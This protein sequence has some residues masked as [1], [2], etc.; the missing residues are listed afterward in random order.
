MTCFGP[1]SV[2]RLQHLH[3]LV[4]HRVGREVD[5]RLHRRDRDELEEVVLEDVADRAGLLVVAGAPLDADRLGDR[6]LDV[7]DELPVP[8]RLEDAVREPQ[9]QHVLNRLLAEVVVDPEHLFLGEMLLKLGVQL[10]RRLEVVT[11]GLLDDQPDPPLGGATRG[12]LVHDRADCARRDCEVVDAVAT[13]PALVVELRED[14]AQF[15]LALVVCEV[16]R[17]VVH[18]GGEVVPHLLVE[19]V[20]RMLLHR[21]LHPLAEP[22][23]ALLGARRTDDPEVLGKQLTDRERVHRG[24]QL[25]RRQ[26]ARRP[27]DDEDAAVR[28]TAKTEPVGERVVVLLRHHSA[29]AAS[30]AWPPNW[31]RSAAFTLAAN[32]SSWRDANRANNAAVITGTG[33]SSAIASAIVQR[34]S[35]ESST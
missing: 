15:V 7:V 5:R 34:P 6:D 3:L 23:V 8:D 17:D 2:H 28:A 19:L 21:L 20:P 24:H 22:V 18:S 25:L 14:V 4:A 1:R 29:F 30:T 16:E 31:L 26:V 27:E 13:G 35:P 10:A 12:D 11:E 32:D 33:T 9:R